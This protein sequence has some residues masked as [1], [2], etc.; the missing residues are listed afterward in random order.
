MSIL[1]IRVI[2]KMEFHLELGFE[3]NE[4]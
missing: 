3:E 1:K 2:S 4:K